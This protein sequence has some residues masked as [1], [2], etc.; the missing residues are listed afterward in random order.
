MPE[1]TEGMLYL[2][3]LR[4]YSVGGTGG[5]GGAGD[6]ALCAAPYAGG[7]GGVGGAG[8]DALCAI[9]YARSYTG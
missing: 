4:C 8:D 6:Y 7:V 2:Q 3:V 1:T 5:V 9:L